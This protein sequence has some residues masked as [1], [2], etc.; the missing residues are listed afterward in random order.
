MQ[1]R[2]TSNPTNRFRDVAVAYDDGETP[3]ASSITILDDA[4]R[5]ILAHND[6][7][8]IGFRWSVNPYRGCLH[9]CAYCLDGDTPILLA[10]GR[11]R[12]LRDLAVG[13]EIFGTRV[14]GHHRRLVKTRVR[15]HW[16]TT[17]PAFRLTLGDGTTLIASGDHRFLTERGWKYVQPG[18]PGQRPHLTPNNTLLGFG[19]FAARAAETADYRRGYI[20]GV[21]RSDALTFDDSHA[22]RF[23]RSLDASAVERV[24]HYLRLAHIH[25]RGPFSPRT[26]F[27]RIVALIGS[28]ALSDDKTADWHAGFVAGIFDAEG[29]RSAHVL[30]ITNADPE[31]LR[32]VSR[33]LAALGFDHAIEPF[34][35]ASGRTPISAVR[36]RGGISAHL[37][38]LHATGCAIGR[39]W[40]LEGLAIRTRADLRVTSIE[41]LGERE[42]FDITTGTEDFIAN[43]VVSHN[44]YARP[45]HEYL[46]LGAG[47]DFDTKIVVKRRAP[48][49]L[50][51]A[52]AKPSWKG[53]L[54]MFSGV[55]DC[56]QLVERELR[57]TRGCL[58]V[59]LEYKNPVSVISKSALLERDVDLFAALAKEARCHVSVSLAWTDAEMA[60]AIEPW[61]PSPE[62]RLRVIETL[63]K[64]GVHVGIMMAPIIPGL[65]DSQMVELME[66]AA[67]AGATT[68]G[69]VLLRLPGAVAQVFPDRLRAAMPLVAD[70]VL[71]RIKET[72]GGGEKLYDSRFHTRGRGEGIYA[73]VIAN[74]FETT[75]K[76]LGLVGRYDD[77]PEDDPDVPTTFRRPVRSGQLKLF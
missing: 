24:E 66:R 70:R 45:T 73:G 51:E 53:E 39:K 19:R 38:F 35:E 36:I 27:K 2:P 76:R 46:D 64:A 52:F 62:R 14:D 65:N 48:E 67:A 11:T 68:A 28:L 5:S 60:R 43:G 54:V 34:R 16:K 63:A 32:R 56:Y 25:T 8:D 77:M 55:T 75:A 50:R 44:C 1:D 22:F 12:A 72:R 31:L 59:C 23:R 57:L 21:I 3:P 13:D 20:T 33:S 74:M 4:S 49:L 15:A 58:E 10:T 9:A 61:A 42:L 30:R 17:K 41:P 37:R 69:W 29:S 18:G 26:T 47:T 71:H 6:S 7:P 40:N